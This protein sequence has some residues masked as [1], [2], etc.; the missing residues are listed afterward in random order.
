MDSPYVDKE[1][2]GEYSVGDVIHNLIKGLLYFGEHFCILYDG[3]DR[4]LVP[5]HTASHC[6]NSYFSTTP[7]SNLHGFKMINVR[8]YQDYIHTV[9]VILNNNLQT[10]Y[11]KHYGIPISV[12]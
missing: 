7:E 5:N 11:H 10:E 3:R 8:V 2:F 9:P 4:S 1:I 12:T 6:W